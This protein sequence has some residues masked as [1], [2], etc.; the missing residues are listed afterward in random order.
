MRNALLGIALCLFASAVN[1]DDNFEAVKSQLIAD[2]PTVDFSRVRYGNNRL[3]L[4]GTEVS[5]ISALSGLPALKWLGLQGTQV[6]DISELN[7]L[8]ALEILILGDTPVSDVSALSGLTALEGLSL[9]G[10]PVS[11]VSALQH[12]IDSGLRISQ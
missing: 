8:T 11:D 5:D 6:S 3:D 7:G 10:T 2:N 4:N 9:T 1:A 12:M